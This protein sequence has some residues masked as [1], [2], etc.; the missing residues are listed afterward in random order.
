M[1]GHC[2]APSLTAA[3]LQVASSREGDGRRGACV[4]HYFEGLDY[5]GELLNSAY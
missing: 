5:C 2:G 3:V 4:S 1:V